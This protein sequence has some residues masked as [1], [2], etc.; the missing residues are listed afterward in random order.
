MKIRFRLTKVGVLL[1][2]TLLS[3]L[4]AESLVRLL[5]PQDGI[6]PFTDLVHGINAPRP[7]V[8]GRHRVP[9]TFDVQVSFT[10]QRFRGRQE[11]STSPAPRVLRLAFLGD[12]FTFGFGADDDETYPAQLQRILQNRVSE[13]ES[14]F[15]TVEVLNAG[16]PGT[17]TGEQACWYDLWVKRFQPHIVILNVHF[18]DV[19]NDLHVPVFVLHDD[20]TVSP[21]PAAELPTVSSLHRLLRATLNATFLY[22]FLAQHSHLFVLVRNFLSRV[23]GFTHWRETDPSAFISPN[24]GKRFTET[25]LPL[26]VGEITWLSN[27]VKAQGGKLLVVFIPNPETVYSPKDPASEGIHR[28]SKA[29]LNLLR[30]LSIREGIPFFDP[31]PTLREAVHS[32]GISLYYSGRDDH[33]NPLGYQTLA[34][35]VAAF[36]TARGIVP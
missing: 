29:I 3:L 7:A 13:G 28:R 26:L 23:V 9:E 4:L 14:L 18:T 1:A 32:A 16:Y 25:G 11:F 8:R 24:P 17:G 33:F 5:A 19:E 10:S 20:G 12:S 31:T 27:Q 21:R 36:L 35:G 6:V 15:T 30:S 2:S 34:K 22:P